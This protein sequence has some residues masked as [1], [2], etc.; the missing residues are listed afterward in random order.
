MLNGPKDEKKKRW[1]KEIKRREK[2]QNI[3][4]QGFPR[5]HPP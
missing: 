1:S 2:G 5:G 4:Q 3:Q